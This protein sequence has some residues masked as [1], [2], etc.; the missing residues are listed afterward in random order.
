MS[1]E[2]LI[3][4]ILFADISG[5]TRMYE[6]LGDER[7]HALI[8][9]CI[10]TISHV[11]VIRGGEIVKTI[12]DQVMCIFEG[13]EQAVQA[14]IEMQR[15]LDTLPAPG[16][17]L[18]PN[19]HVGLHAGPVIRQEGD[20]FGNA[21]NMAARMV[22]LAKPRQI[23][24]TY[25][26]I[27]RLFHAGKVKARCV[28][29]TTIRG[30][31]GEFCIYEIVWEEHDQTVILRPDLELPP[32]G[33]RLQLALGGKALQV[34]SANPVVTLGRQ[35]CND[36]VLSDEIASRSH[37]RIEYHRGRFVLID[38]SSNGSFIYVEGREPVIVHHDAFELSASG[39]IGL[40]RAV[41]PSSPQAIH[42]TCEPVEGEP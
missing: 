19:I 10:Q 16:D 17:H 18:R 41:V 2:D 23:I 24:T 40:G 11:A 8:S 22:Y 3:L 39:I 21:V 7:A 30:K 31:G 4:A 14:A 32:Q 20:V 37:A 1:G 9:A 38:Q 29:R 33:G 27:E 26:T 34:S 35:D 15:S 25:P 13:V 28:D 5:S 36:L 42:F 12:G 6:S